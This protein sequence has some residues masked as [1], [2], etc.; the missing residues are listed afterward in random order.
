MAATVDHL[1][2]HYRVTVIKGFTDMHGLVVPEGAT[3]VIR[4]IAIDWTTMDISIDW[5]RDGRGPDQGLERMTFAGTATDGPRN[6]HMK[7]YFDKG[8]LSLPPRE[9]KPEPEVEPASATPDPPR[10]K[11]PDESLDAYKGKQ[12]GGEVL[13]HELTVAC[14]C[15][16]AFHRQII[17]AGRLNVAA[18][19]KCGA[20]TVTRTV[21]DDGRFTGDAWTAYW[22]VPT[23][24]KIVDWLGRFPRVSINYAGAPWRWPMPARLVR[25]PMRLYPANVRVNSE[26]ELKALEARLDEAQKGYTRV[27]RLREACKGVKPLPMEIP[28][29]HYG[30]DMIAN[31]LWLQPDADLGKLTHLAQLRSPAA[32]LAADLLIRRDDAYLRMMELL[33]SQDEEVFSAGITMLRDARALF[34]GPDDPR[35][36]PALLALMNT[37]S[38]DALPNTSRVVSWFRFEALLVAIAD[39]GVNTA[40]MKDGLRALMLKLARKDA[41]VVDCI[42]IVINEL[43]GVDNRPEKYR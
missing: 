15:G 14:D 31:A 39:L 21:G 25:Y 5:E 22:T 43:N 40:E 19:L 32:E 6:N 17:P 27:E 7:E 26:D 42:R 3:G 4:M 2:S 16:A 23:P 1:S 37:L 28:E 12:P 10:P 36:A 13:L 20:V 11:R 9:P 33:A 30:F 35:L 18:C 24:Q 34:S 29:D 41:Q 38:L 8:E